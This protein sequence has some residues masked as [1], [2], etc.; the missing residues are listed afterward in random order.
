MLCFSKKY[1]VLAQ[2]DILLLI[3]MASQNSNLGRL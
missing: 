3:V 1:G 2:T